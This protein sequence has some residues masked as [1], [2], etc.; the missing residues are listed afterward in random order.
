LRYIYNN[1]ER[2]EWSIIYWLT[3]SLKMNSKVSNF[4]L[5]EKR[6]SRKKL[7]RTNVISHREVAELCGMSYS[8]LMKSKKR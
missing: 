2:V 8:E 4:N 6:N 5:G 1:P 3:S 7:L